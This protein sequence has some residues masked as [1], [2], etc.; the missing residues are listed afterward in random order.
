M[1]THITNFIYICIGHGH[2]VLENLTK[3]PLA[4]AVL[5]PLSQS[6]SSVPVGPSLARRS[7]ARTH[8][9]ANIWGQRM[10]EFPPLSLIVVALGGREGW[11]V[12]GRGRRRGRGSE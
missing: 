5:E 1:Y 7:R 4:R 6:C 3:M 8:A 2:L 9:D 12:G 11:R 10:G